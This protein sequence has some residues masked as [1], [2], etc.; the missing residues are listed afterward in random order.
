MKI[1][2]KQNKVSQAVWPWLAPSPTDQVTRQALP[3]ALLTLAIAWTIAGLFLYLT[4]T[5]MS[6]LVIILSSFIFFTSQFS[7]LLFSKIDSVF[8]KLALYIGQFITYISLV[9]F[10]Y[11]C[12]TSVRLIQLIRKVDP[13]TRR[14][15]PDAISYWEDNNTKSGKANYRR[16]F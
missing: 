3:K 6:L 9:P 12:F 10:F 1:D 11:L 7:P 15:N 4:Y 16:Q 2:F 8:H 13:M 5:S 14:Y